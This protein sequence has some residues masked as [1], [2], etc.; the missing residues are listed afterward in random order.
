MASG[1]LFPQRKLPKIDG[2]EILEEIGRGGCGIVFRGRNSTLGH[3]VAIKTLISPP[4]D[5]SDETM[6]RF[7]R[8]ARALAKVSHPNVVHIFDIRRQGA[9]PWI[10]MEYVDGMSLARRLKDP[11]PLP[12]LDSLYF[13]SET[14]S[15]LQAV[16]EEGIIHRDV[17][18]ENLHITSRQRIKLMDFGVA[19][20]DDSFA[21]AHGQMLGTPEFMSP[22]QFRGASPI[23]AR[24]DVYCLGLVLYTMLCGRP[25][26]SG[27]N[28][29][30]VAFQQAHEPPEPP[31]KLRPEISQQVE[32]VIL[33]AI[34][35]DPAKRYQSAEEFHAALEAF[36]TRT[37]TGVFV[38]IVEA[39]SG[40]F[41]RIPPG[42]TPPTSQ[43][44]RTPSEETPGPVVRSVS[45]PGQPAVLQAPA[46]A[47]QAPAAPPPPPPPRSGSASSAPSP[48]QS[49]SA[50]TPGAPPSGSI[51][52]LMWAVMGILA[53]AIGAGIAMLF[54]R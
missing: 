47:Q 32:A 11:T 48:A 42:H 9:A 36:V 10:I 38:N 1:E 8:E 15:A 25:P 19:R 6:R 23:D 49:P 43:I 20:M 5:D 17:K 44:I 26:F 46:P 39:S 37:A 24:A 35:K 13:A 27:P 50:A 30:A 16:H 21:T 34:E 54:I 7:F 31:S 40:S 14:A 33:K 12:V 18:P 3:D 2:Y 29:F 51:S 45:R 4:S 41:P 22:E 28:H 52:I 53:L